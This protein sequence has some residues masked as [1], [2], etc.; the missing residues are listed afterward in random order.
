MGQA[1][2][3]DKLRLFPRIVTDLGEEVSVLGLAAEAMFNITHTFFVSLSQVF[4]ADDPL[5]YDLLYRLS[6]RILVRAS[7]NF[8]GES[9]AIVEY[10]V[11][12]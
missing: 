10:E 9:R 5:R 4:A 3:I 7:T 8:A 1:L 6:D 12:F 11:R 2:S